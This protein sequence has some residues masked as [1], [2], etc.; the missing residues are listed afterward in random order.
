MGFNESCSLGISYG[1]AYLA[2]IHYANI[3]SNDTV[4]IHSATGA[5]G[6]ASIEI[7]KY[8]GCK[9]IATAST[10]HKRNY[11]KNLGC[12]DFI[13]DSRD[14]NIYKNKI[15]T[16][17]NNIGVDVILSSSIDEHLIANLDILKPMGKLLDVS[18]KNLYN[19]SSLPLTNFIKMI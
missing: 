5:L 18:K 2:L 1:T 15:L 11:L 6:L 9:I 14:I 8:I 7:C 16:F 3:S 10:D 19:G 4:L 17:T 13:T 12:I